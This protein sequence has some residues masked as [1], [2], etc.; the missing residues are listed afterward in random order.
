MASWFSKIHTVV[1]AISTAISSSLVVTGPDADGAAA[2]G[3][4]VQCAG[5]DGAGD[6]QA[7]ETDADGQQKIVQDVAADL[8]CTEASSA[9]IKTAVELLDDA[10][11]TLA[12]AIP[13]KGLLVCADEGGNAE[14][15]E[16]TSGRLKAL[17]RIQDTAGGSLSSTANSL[18]VKEDS[19]PALLLNA[20]APLA[21][22]AWSTRVTDN[23]ASG[24]WNTAKAIDV[25]S[26]T[27]HLSALSVSLGTIAGIT[28]VDWYLSW[29][30]AGAEP[31][32]DRQSWTL[33]TDMALDRA[34]TSRIAVAKIDIDLKRPAGVGTADTIYLHTYG[35]AGT[36]AGIWTASG[37]Y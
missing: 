11:A 3:D 24:A 26:D 18:H 12:A 19:A 10:V 15:L 30:A 33:A 7:F 21:D 22:R 6:V 32:T 4:P 28:D 34:G 16:M 1:E 35:T 8:N 20:Q 27:V 37:S 2:T 17:A 36:A 9:A 5:V 25:G 23:V 14:P 31:I 13:A 29:D